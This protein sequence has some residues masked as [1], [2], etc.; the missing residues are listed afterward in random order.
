MGATETFTFSFT[1][2]GLDTLTELIFSNALSA[3]PQ[4]GGA[5]AFEARFRGFNNC[6]SDKVSGIFLSPPP[7]VPTPS[8][9]LLL[10]S[11]L[12]GL[13]IMGRRRLH[14]ASISKKKAGNWLILGKPQPRR[15]WG[16][17]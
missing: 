16:P 13:A 1:G 10:G 9:L 11:G 12:A 4:G 3:K 6:E 17:N 7:P 5:K 8:T 2:Y 15:R 14:N